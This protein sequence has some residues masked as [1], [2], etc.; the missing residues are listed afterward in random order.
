MAIVWFFG[1]RPPGVATVAFHSDDYRA[2]VDSLTKRAEAEDLNYIWLEEHPEGELGKR[3]EQLGIACALYVHKAWGV[4]WNGQFIVGNRQRGLVVAG[5]VP[6]LF[7][8]AKVRAYK[9]VDGEFERWSKSE[10]PRGPSIY[11]WRN[12][13]EG[14]R[15][16]TSG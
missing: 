3:M 5:D 11:N 13:L 12:P 6:R 8:G 15:C 1:L 2:L 16:T 7:G 10:R 14:D 4:N 9:I